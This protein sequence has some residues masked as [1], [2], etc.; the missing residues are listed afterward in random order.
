MVVGCA[1][2][3]SATATMIGAAIASAI[4]TTVGGGADGVTDTKA[5]KALRRKPES[6]SE[7]AKHARLCI[8]Q[9]VQD[10]AAQLPLPEQLDAAWRPLI[11]DRVDINALVQEPQGGV[12]VHPAPFQIG[13]NA[14][15]RDATVPGVLI[16]PTGLQQRRDDL[17]PSSPARSYRSSP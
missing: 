13:Q 9:G 8:A 1:T 14:R 5:C 12:H 4:V 15:T 11:W 10:H 6:T 17:A 16:V 3:V 7:F 2:S